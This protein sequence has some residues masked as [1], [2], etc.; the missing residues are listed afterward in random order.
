MSVMRI[1]PTIAEELVRMH[2]QDLRLQGRVAGPRRR[3]HRGLG[4]MLAALFVDS[5]DGRDWQSRADW[6]PQEE[7]RRARGAAYL[8]APAR[9][10]CA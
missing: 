10:D 2:Q 7:L 3:A 6:Q 9:R 4:S 8:A 5:R 1:H